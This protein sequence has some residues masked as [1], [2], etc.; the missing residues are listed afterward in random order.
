MVLIKASRGGS[1]FEKWDLGVRGRMS[2]LAVG[3]RA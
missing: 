1:R 3:Y 2:D